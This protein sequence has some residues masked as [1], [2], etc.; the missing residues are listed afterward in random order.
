MEYARI[1]KEESEMEMETGMHRN[2]T[3]EDLARLGLNRKGKWQ[4][5]I[6]DLEKLPEGVYAELIDGE[7]F[8]MMTTPA[9]IHQDILMGLSFQ[10]ELYIQK[11]KGRC[12]VFPAPFGVEIKNDIYNFV[13]PDITLICDDEKVDK[14]GCY[15]APDLVIE[16]VSPSNRKMDYVRKLALY[17]EAGVREY[18][19]V[20]PKHEQV[21][22][23]DWEKSDSPTLYPFSERIKVGVYDDLY[24]DLANRHGTLDEVLAKERQ[25]AIQ[26]GLEALVNSLKAVL[27]D[28]DAV[29]HAVKQ[30]EIF[31]DVSREEIARYYD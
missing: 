6:K 31:K 11:K 3:E 19:I 8:V 24:L 4:Y 10:V 26:Q 28:L 7:I 21:T 23:Y 16:I 17:H 9:T 2:L 30:N 22:V 18:W 27:P 5:T 12:R 20:D 1:R 15:G 25:D 14:G 29:C 13:V